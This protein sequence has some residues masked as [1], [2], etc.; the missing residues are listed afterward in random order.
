MRRH[1]VPNPMTHVNPRHQPD[2]G[3]P[4]GRITVMET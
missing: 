1:R 4:G 3:H 2:L